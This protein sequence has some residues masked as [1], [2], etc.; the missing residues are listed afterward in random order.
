MSDALQVLATLR[1]PAPER[2]A[3]V[4][5]AYR[6][7]CG[8]KQGQDGDD[9]IRV[10]RI[11]EILGLA[12]SSYQ[13]GWKTQTLSFARG[14]LPTVDAAFMSLTDDEVIAAV[15]TYADG[16]SRTGAITK[17]LIEGGA[18]GTNPAAAH[19]PLQRSV[20]GALN[21]AKPVTR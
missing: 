11:D 8:G 16:G 14:A 21:R 1:D 3:R 19:G 15:K 20:D 13:A 7:M 2:A 9:G 6:A 4:R 5:K 12:A 18:L 17:L 10:R